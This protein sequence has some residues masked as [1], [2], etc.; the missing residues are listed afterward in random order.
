MNPGDLVMVDGKRARII[1]A[2]RHGVYALRIIGESEL[3]E[4]VGSDLRVADE[5]FVEPSCYDGPIIVCGV[6]AMDWAISMLKP[7]EYPRTVADWFTIY[8]PK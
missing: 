2:R 1:E 4:R 8:T 5:P 7:V 3:I 6:P